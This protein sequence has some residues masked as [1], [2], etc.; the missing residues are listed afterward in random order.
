MSDV[1]NAAFPPHR[2]IRQLTLLA[3]GEL[4]A[5]TLWFSATAVLPALSA[6]WALSPT[7]AAWLTAAVQAGFVVG[8][9]ASA[10][11]NLPDVLPPRRMFWLSA[12]AGALAN[13]LLAWWAQG[14]AAALVLRFLTGLFLAGVYPPGMKIAAGHVSGRGRGLAIGVLV[15]SLTLGSATPHLV[16]GLFDARGL[17]YPL[18]LTVSSVLALLGAL[19]VATLVT[20]GPYAPAPAPF[21]PRQLGRVLRDRAVLLANLGYFGHMWELYA[22]WAWLAV[23]LSAALGSADPAAPRL[24]A[25]VTIGIAGAAGAFL[26]GWLADRIGRTTVTIGAMAISGACCVLSAWAYAGPAWLLFAFGLVWGASVIADSA[27]FSASV[28]ELSAP[29]YMGTALTLQT[30]LGFALTMVTIWGLPLLAEHVG[31]RYAFL[32]LAPGPFLGCWAMAAL[33]RRPEAVRL[34][35]GRR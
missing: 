28:T 15:G 26:G 13:L 31:W 17:S 1:I 19:M 4:L 23:F 16:A 24:A 3:V 32:A 20:D 27:Q 12:L 30:S 6:A 25:F 5:M 33:R 8:A 9:L 14:I 18:V 22:V 10:V 7:G 35:G 29:A 21:D 34:A 11:L 2:P